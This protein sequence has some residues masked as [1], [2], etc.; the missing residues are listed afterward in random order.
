M[1]HYTPTTQST[2]LLSTQEIKEILAWEGMQQ[3][4]LI[5][6]WN[7]QGIY[8]LML[9]TKGTSLAL[10][11]MGD[12]VKNKDIFEDLSKKYGPLRYPYS[13]PY[14][15]YTNVNQHALWYAFQDDHNTSGLRVIDICYTVFMNA[16]LPNDEDGGPR[17]WFTDTRPLVIEGIEKIKKQL[18]QS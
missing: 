12:Y 6:D 4:G 18:G 3:D 16:H 17:D 11:L 10:W 7:I 13:P 8:E 9:L 5:D 15:E 1:S 14:S 2:A